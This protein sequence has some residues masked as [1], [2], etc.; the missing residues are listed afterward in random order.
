MS[1]LIMPHLVTYLLIPSLHFFADIELISRF[2]QLEVKFGELERGKT[3]FDTLM[4]SYPKRTDLWLV[5]IDT[6]TKAGHLESARYVSLSGP[7]RSFSRFSFL[8]PTSVELR[9]TRPNRPSLGIQQV[10]VSLSRS[11]RTSHAAP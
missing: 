1:L 8:L 7:I 9:L 10:Q 6:L 5:Y 2:G 11:G 3:M 4:M